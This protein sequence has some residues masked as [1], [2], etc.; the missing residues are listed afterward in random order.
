MYPADRY[1][2][3]A[4]TRRWKSIFLLLFLLISLRSFSQVTDSADYPVLWLRA[5][6]GV[7]TT[8]KDFT[9][10][11]Y[12]GIFL[13]RERMKTVTLNYNPALSFNG[14]DDSVRIAC[15]LDS[16]SEMTYMA[17]FIPG[18]Y[19]RNA[20]GHGWCDPSQYPDDHA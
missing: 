4:T 19:R 20:L 1:P 2:I 7:T 11:G 12:D 16:L 3:P 15:N 9:G 13:G 18:Q 14:I 8:W 17:V 5:D 10:H 6:S